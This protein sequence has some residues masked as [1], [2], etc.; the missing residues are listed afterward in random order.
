[1]ASQPFARGFA[2]HIRC[3]RSPRSGDTL[4]QLHLVAKRAANRTVASL[5]ERPA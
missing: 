4:E 1:V 5:E 3:G 2:R